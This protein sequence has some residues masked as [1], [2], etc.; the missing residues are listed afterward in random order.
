MIPESLELAI[1]KPFGLE[2]ARGSSGAI[3]GAVFIRNVLS[4]FGY[5]RLN[6]QVLWDPGKAR[7]ALLAWSPRSPRVLCTLLHGVLKSKDVFKKLRYIAIVHGQAQGLQF[8][9]SNQPRWN[10][11]Q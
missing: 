10:S 3:C 4:H 1:T 11:R 9:R 7:Y 5:V 2:E 6:T 8:S